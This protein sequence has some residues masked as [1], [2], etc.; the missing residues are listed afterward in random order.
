MKASKWMSLILA[1]ALVT[2][3]GTTAFAAEEAT[4]AEEVTPAVEEVVEPT[5]E[6]IIPEERTK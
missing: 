2:A 1:L 6:E 4:P 3:N 5:E